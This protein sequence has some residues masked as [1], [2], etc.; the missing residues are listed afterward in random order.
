MNIYFFVHKVRVRQLTGESVESVEQQ[1]YGA[2]AD[3]PA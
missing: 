2:D 1:E 3:H